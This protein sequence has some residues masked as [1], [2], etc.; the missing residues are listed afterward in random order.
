MPNKT[1]S[2]G[3]KAS[4]SDT[5]SNDGCEFIQ[6]NTYNRSLIEAS[7]DPL[8]TINPDG[9]ISDV[10]EATV[11]I[12]GYSR[13]ELIGTDFSHY[14]IESEKAKAGYKSVLRDGSVTNYELRIRHRNGKITTVIYN[15]STFKDNAGNIAGVF[16]AVRD[17]TDRKKAEEE[18]YHL[19]AIVKNSDD[20]IIG[21]SLEGIIQSWNA[22]A[23][24][25]CGY[26]EAEVIGKS[27]SILVPPDQIDDIDY[28]LEKIKQGNPVIH[29]ET[30]RRKK[31]GSLIHVSLTS[32]PIKDLN[33]KL[34]GV[35][36]IARDITERK[37]VEEERSNFAAI[38]EN[39]DDAIIG[40]SLDGIIL[41][42][43]TGAEKIYGYSAAEAIGRS[44]SILVPPDQVDDLIHILDKF[45]HGEP[46]FHYETPRMKKD[47]SLIHVSLTSS[48]IKDRNGKLVG[49]STIARD[50]TER[51]KAEEEMV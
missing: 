45:K 18:K 5:R 11:R 26:T 6:A 44:M 25:I 48:P 38:V 28:I 17:V 33:G 51:K 3:K 16:A 50:I 9:T 37:N 34:I 1:G 15:A 31:D 8:V 46:V 32:S 24:K 21:K 30:P 41:S 47:G 7:L 42:W 49:V 10:N 23:E 39:S 36:T 20:A 43:N 40:K 19:A 12:T 27:I 14:F 29:Y 2:S 4:N 13:E 35:S 22:G